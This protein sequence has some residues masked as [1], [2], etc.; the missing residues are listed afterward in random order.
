MRRPRPLI[1]LLST[2][3]AACALGAAVAP[4]ALANFFPGDAIDGPS[5]DI[6]AL[7]EVDLARDGTGALVYVKRSEG[8]DRVVAARFEGGIFRP[9]ERLD[10]GLPTAS[11]QPVVGAAD[12]GRLAVA[13]VSG[14]VVHGVVRPAAGQPWS[15]PTP[16]GTGSDPAVDVSI[17]GTG[18]ATFTS[19]GGDVR[20]ARLDRRTNAWELLAQPADVDPA[21]P[22]GVGAGRSRVAVSADGV[23]VVTWGE[24][25]HVYAR[26]MFGNTLSPSPQD[27][28]PP[29]FAGRVSVASDLPDVDAE[30]D[31]SYAWVVFRQHFADGGSQ[32]LARRQRG[33][34]FDPPVA[35]GD[36]AGEPVGAPR[37]DLNGRGVG[38]ATTTGALTGQPIVARTERDLFGAGARVF[39]PSVAAP[40]VAPAISEN[41]EGVLAAVLGGAGEAPYVGVRSIEEATLGPERVLSRPEL[42]PVAPELGFDVAT[43]RASG[44]VIAWVQGAPGARS[45]VSG[46]YDRL[47]G[48]FAGYTSQRCCQ[49]PRPQLSWQPAFSIWGALRYVVTVDGQVVGETTATR[50][51]PATPLR[52]G[53]RRWQVTAFDVRG[54]TRR[55]RTRTVQVDA[56][57]PLLNVTY[58]RERR[59]VTLSVRARDLASGG[60]RASGIR[61]VVVSWGDRTRGS[62]GTS[63]LRA[64]H[65]YRRAGSYRLVVTATDKAGNTRVWR[66]T[67]RTG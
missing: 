52:G 24:A 23:G 62:R 19:A 28:T 5:A 60:R 10:A 2:L 63:R 16:L 3:A 35:V 59:L 27:L 15:A 43:D 39:S 33:T 67:V 22:A 64:Q 21:R 1:S 13:F 36:L 14:G 9:A 37:V 31:S 56:V 45:I 38:V 51:R 7:G 8:V 6:R 41:N 61:S 42:G 30:D 44:S 18:Y 55:T 54:Q 50:L 17:N 25:G 53:T 66:R 57:R 26:K 48:F 11:S 65:R 20:V 32:A 58:R 49:G 46:F 4:A 40:A 34:A 29:T 12:A 47:P